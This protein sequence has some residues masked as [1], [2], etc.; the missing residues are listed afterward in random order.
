MDL[1]IK[2][3]KLKALDGLALYKWT[4]SRYRMANSFILLSDLRLN[5]LTCN[6]GQ[7][8]F[9]AAAPILYNRHGRAH[10]QFNDQAVLHVVEGG[11]KGINI[12]PRQLRGGECAVPAQFCGS[13]VIDSPDQP[14]WVARRVMSMGC[15][16]VYPAGRLVVPELFRISRDPSA[17]KPLFTKDLIALLG[18]DKDTPGPVLQ[19]LFRRRISSVGASTESGWA[20][21]NDYVSRGGCCVVSSRGITPR[22]GSC[23]QEMPLAAYRREVALRE[24]IINTG[25]K[26]DELSRTCD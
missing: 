25:D 6:K 10:I 24:W 13:F 1:K 8:V 3:D 23:V 15:S 4:A 11:R 17:F 19:E 20:I 9:S 5:T 26:S 2:L 12:A 18:G 14:H 21:S 7:V 22:G 16:L